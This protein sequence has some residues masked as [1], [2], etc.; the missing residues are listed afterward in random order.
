MSGDQLVS[1]ADYEFISFVVFSQLFTSISIYLYCKVILSFFKFKQLYQIW[2]A[3]NSHKKLYS[4]CF[5]FEKFSILIIRIVFAHLNGTQ[6]EWEE[7]YLACQITKFAKRKKYF[8]KKKRWFPTIC[9][10]CIRYFSCF[11]SRLLRLWNVNCDWLLRL[12]RRLTS[13]ASSL[14]FRK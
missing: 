4:S 8:R 14:T 2:F 10:H 13:S 12:K 7:P 5:R 3:I 9:Q 1:E 6:F 11:L